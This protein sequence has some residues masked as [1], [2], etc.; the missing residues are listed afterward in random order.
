MMQM[1]QIHVMKKLVLI[2][3]LLLVTGC[4]VY[5]PAPSYYGSPYPYSPHPYYGYYGYRYYPDYGYYGHRY[6]QN[7]L[8][9]CPLNNAKD[10]YTWFYG[11]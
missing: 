8:S 7:Y 3:L 5:I 2:T 10:C 1:K 4:V 6:Y 11:Q 9:N